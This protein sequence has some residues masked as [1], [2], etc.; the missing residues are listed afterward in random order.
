MHGVVNNAGAL[1]LSSLL[2]KSLFSS[3]SNAFLWSK[4]NHKVLGQSLKKDKQ[5]FDEF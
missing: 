3:K 1:T 4:K 2:I 5:R